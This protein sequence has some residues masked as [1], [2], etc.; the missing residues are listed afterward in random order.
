MEE[1]TDK[2]WQGLR[3]SARTRLEIRDYSQTPAR[4]S[5]FLDGNHPASINI[6][7]VEIIARQIHQQQHRGFFGEFARE[8]EVPFWPRQWA[9]AR[10]FRDTAKGFHI[11]PP[12][13]P[14][15]EHA[16]AWFEKLFGEKSGNTPADPSLRPY[17]KERA[18]G[19][20]GRNGRATRPC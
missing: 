15:G 4:A 6:P 19:M 10:M 12:H 18:C 11:H 8:G 7:G 9:T 14:E 5:D 2:R 13:V 20:T 1:S 3:E 16:A 17:T